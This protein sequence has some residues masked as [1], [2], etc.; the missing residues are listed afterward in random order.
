M[1]EDF[2]SRAIVRISVK[3]DDPDGCHSKDQL[4][5]IARN[6]EISV[7]ITAL[8]QSLCASTQE[9]SIFQVDDN[10]CGYVPQTIRD[11]ACTP[12]PI[13]APEEDDEGNIPDTTATITFP[14]GVDIKSSLDGVFFGYLDTGDAVFESL[15]IT[16]VDEE[17]RIITYTIS[18]LTTPL[19]ICQHY[20]QF[21]SPTPDTN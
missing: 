21:P 20:A 16:D 3:G 2:D 7:D 9:D 4:E 19:E 6:L 12:S 1:A 8:K 17:N 10:G 18:G 14:E 11:V 15:R 5:E 13:Q